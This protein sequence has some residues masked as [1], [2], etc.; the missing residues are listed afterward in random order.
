M[1]QHSDAST[2][3][4][5][6]RAGGARQGAGAA[7]PVLDTYKQFAQASPGAAFRPFHPDLFTRFF[8]GGRCSDVHRMTKRKTPTLWQEKS[9]FKVSKLYLDGLLDIQKLSHRLST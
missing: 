3:R 5:R 6:V 4:R 9:G 1:R 2:E 7:P 8:W